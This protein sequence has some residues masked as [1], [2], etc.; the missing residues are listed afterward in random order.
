MITEEVTNQENKRPALKRHCDECGKEYEYRLKT[1]RFCSDIC[2]VNADK[3][4]KSMLQPAT[5][6]PPVAMPPKTPLNM[7]G[8]AGLQQVFY[9]IPPH[10]QMMI[11]HYRGE[12][13]RWENNFNEEKKKRES[14]EQQYKELKDSTERADKP[15]G[16]QGFV[17]QNQEICKELITHFGPT[18]AKIMERNAPAQIAGAPAV[19]ENAKAF[20]EW[21]P[22]A[23]PDVQTQ[24]WLLIQS[25]SQLEEPALL[26]SIA[27]ILNYLQN[28]NNTRQTGTHH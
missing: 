3:K 10:A 23:S 5:T 18:L 22:K 7:E 16:L 14:A 1:S 27:N 26:F 4:K 15:K 11:D 21:L 19:D 8:L 25:L 24:F 13:S 20:L 9:A 28:G 17:Q 2:R 12:V 6:F